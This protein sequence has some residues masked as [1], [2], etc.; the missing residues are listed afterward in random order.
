[1]STRRIAFLVSIV[2]VVL[3]GSA[4]LFRSCSDESI[5]E[6]L[7]DDDRDDHLVACLVPDT[8]D[9]FNEAK[10]LGTFNC[11]WEQRADQPLRRINGV[12]G[13]PVFRFTVLNFCGERV[14]VT[15]S[16]T[17]R[18][19]EPSLDFTTAVCGFA[20]TDGSVSFGEVEANDQVTRQCTARDYVVQD[21]ASRSRDF[22]LKA[23]SFGSSAV[24]RPFDPQVVLEKAGA[25]TVVR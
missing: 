19:G 13:S 4:L 12:S 21:A 15:L 11:S 20:D 5:T 2:G 14:K 22:V 1:M 3:I 7:C 16:L 8:S 10:R 17:R 25:E 6:A 23:E 24:S 18:A 9:R